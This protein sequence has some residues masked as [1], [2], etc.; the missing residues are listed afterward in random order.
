MNRSFQAKSQAKSQALRGL[1][2]CAALFVTLAIVG[3]I[4]LLSRHYGAEA[5]FA[6]AK[7]IVIASDKR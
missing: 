5:Q 3:S 1:F 7:L 4:D 2:A 6:A